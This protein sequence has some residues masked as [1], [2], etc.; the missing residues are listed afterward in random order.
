MSNENKETPETG[1]D[2]D[3]LDSAFD[4]AL[5]ILSDANAKVTE[6]LETMD[7]PEAISIGAEV[8]DDGNIHE[9]DDDVEAAANAE[10]ETAETEPS[11]Q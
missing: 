1:G 6:V 11:E 4:E 10:T 3:D 2:L 9:G 7:N 5:S 8:D